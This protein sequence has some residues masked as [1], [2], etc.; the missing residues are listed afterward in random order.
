M[1]NATFRLTPSKVT[2]YVSTLVNVDYH[3]TIPLT[4]FGSPLWIR[5][6]KV[7]R[8]VFVI[9][10][11]RHWVWNHS[12]KSGHIALIPSSTFQLTRTRSWNGWKIHELTKFVRHNKDRPMF[13]ISI[14]FS[15]SFYGTCTILRRFYCSNHSVKRRKNGNNLFV[16]FG[17]RAVYRNALMLWNF[18]HVRNMHACI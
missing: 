18:R 9:S 5:Y 4:E 16:P 7:L 15:H 6:S 2:M 11:R 8:R 1:L 3:S 14:N 10:T 13:H 12:N 17:L